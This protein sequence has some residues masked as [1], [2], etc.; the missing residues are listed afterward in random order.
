MLGGL[1]AT[2]VFVG[3]LYLRARLARKGSVSIHRAMSAENQHVDR[4]HLPS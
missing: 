4:D 3:L 2:L 1:G